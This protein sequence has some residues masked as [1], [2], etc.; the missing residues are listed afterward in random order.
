[1]KTHSRSPLPDAFSLRAPAK[2]NWFLKIREKRSDGYHSIQSLMQ[3]VTLYDTLCFERTAAIELECDQNIPVSD[4]LVYKAACLL[5]ECTTY[6][7]GARIT[8]KKNIPVGAGLGGGSSNAACALMGLNTLWGL[9]LAANA[10]RDLGARI[11][12]DVPFFFDTPCSFVEGR[13]ETSTPVSLDQSATLLLVKPPLSVSTAW[14]Y[15]AFD[16]KRIS[17]GDTGTLSLSFDEKLKKKPLDIKLFCQA[18]SKR[19]FATL[20]E[21]Q[22][23]ALENVVIARHPI[24]QEIKERLLD[25]GAVMSAMSGSGPTVFGVFE[26][27]DRAE[28]AAV[29]MSPS[30]CC[31]VETLI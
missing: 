28:Q 29:T 9:N 3:C 14:A 12:S 7:K 25:G 10:L 18:L 2:I 16:Q 4:N 26:D 19:D 15:D 21:M 8:V 5:K 24:V 13:G 27:R 23:N 1:M 17:E 6:R 11:G 31:I 20:T 22:E 30:W